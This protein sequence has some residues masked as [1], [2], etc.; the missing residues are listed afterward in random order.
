MKKKLTVIT[1]M[2]MLSIFSVTAQE[3]D[4]LRREKIEFGVKAGLNISNVW[5][6]K[7]QEFEADRKAGFAGG[8]FMGIPIG[9]YLGIQPEV[10]ISQKGFKGSGT[11]LGFPYSTTRTTTFLDVP[12]LVQLKPA[13]FIT[14]LAGPQFSYLLNQK[15]VY[16][17]GTNSTL[18]EKEFTNDNIRKNILGC[19]VGVDLIYDHLVLS[20]RAGWDF[21]T[22]NGDGTSLTPRYK[23]QMLQFTVGLKI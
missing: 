2:C 22:N 5:D 4:D 19:V 13:S 9:K 18:Q 21:Q 6:S 14:F 1:S 3:D 20:G 17:F 10:L 12:L 7:G 23:N 15:D 8:V 16:T 11:L